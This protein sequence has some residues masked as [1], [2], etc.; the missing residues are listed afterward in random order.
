[1]R[2]LKED[3]VAKETLPVSFITDMMSK[4]WDEVGYL[5]EASA[6]ISEHYE[7]TTKI[8]QLMQELMDAYLVFIGQ[9]ELYLHDKEDIVA[10]ATDVVA[11]TKDDVDE[12]NTNNAVR[13]QVTKNEKPELPEAELEVKPISEPTNALGRMTVEDDFKDFAAPNTELADI[14][15]EEPEDA[16]EF[17]IDFDDPDLSEPRI[18]DDELYGHEYSELENNRLKVN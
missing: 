18:T 9:L 12:T 10:L 17:F 13:S 15:T 4:G 1:M 5:R 3:T 6:A 11:E 2:I 14:P 8:E 16:F 7:E